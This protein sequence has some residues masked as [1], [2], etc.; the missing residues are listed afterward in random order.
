MKNNKI[1]KAFF[2]AL[3]IFAALHFFAADFSIAQ[4][5]GSA[6]CAPS[7]TGEGD[8]NACVNNI[9]RF[10]IIA[11]SIGAVLMFVIA[12]YL[13]MFSGGSDKQVGTAKSL[14]SSSITGMVILLAGLLI[15]RQ[16][17]PDL[18]YIKSIS[19]EQITS[20][21]W[22]FGGG[23]G[24]GGGGL[25]GGGGPI[26]TGNWKD[27]INA[28]SQ[29]YSL[30][31]CVLDTI[32]KKESSGGNPSAIGHDNHSSKDDPFQAGSPPKHGLNW[33]YSHGIGITQWTIFPYTHR[34]GKWPD[35]N[36][37]QRLVFG[38]WYGVNDFLNPNLSIDL[39]GR[40]M[41]DKLRRNGNNVR[42]AFRDYNGSG[43]RAEAYAN[44]AMRLYNI[45]K[46]Q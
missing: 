5:D 45:C 9:Y 27:A 43:S 10:S 11:A 4:A 37:P 20:R 29:K 18:L 16:I 33:N 42:T 23:G 36:V 44:D 32:L 26:S 34:Y 21:D 38:K 8:V 46:G 22:E 6:I 41:A 2:F 35:P 31:P 15:L 25:G 13:Y 30:D 19:P 3:A 24:G 1:I 7:D 17:N 40:D 28:A 12:G 14:M 39:T